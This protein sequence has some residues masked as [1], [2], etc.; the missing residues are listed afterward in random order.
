MISPDHHDPANSQL[1][2]VNGISTEISRAITSIREVISPDKQ[3]NAT[4]ANFVNR[5]DLNDLNVENDGD[6]GF[7]LPL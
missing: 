7:N 6:V 5:S 2:A 1:P 3:L 4:G